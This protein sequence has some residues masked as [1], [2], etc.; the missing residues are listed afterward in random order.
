[1][2]KKPFSI[3]RHSLLMPRDEQSEYRYGPKNGG[4]A[5]F[6][7]SSSSSTSF[8]STNGGI[9]N[10]NK[11]QNNEG[12]PL[13]SL[14]RSL[15]QINPFKNRLFRLPA[16][17]RLSRSKKV[18]ARGE[19]FTNWNF[20]RPSEE[21]N[22]SANNSFSDKHGDSRD[23]SKIKWKTQVET[24][25]DKQDTDQYSQ[26]NLGENNDLDE[27]LSIMAK[28]TNKNE[29]GG[30]CRL[31]SIPDSFNQNSQLLEKNS[32]KHQKLKGDTVIGI[33]IKFNEFFN[34][35]QKLSKNGKTNKIRSRPCI[36]SFQDPKISKNN[37]E[38]MLNPPINNNNHCYNQKELNIKNKINHQNLNC[39]NMLPS[40][41][42]AP[43]GEIYA[44]CW[45]NN[46]YQQPNIFLP[47]SSQPPPS[48]PAAPQTQNLPL[49]QRP[50]NL[51]L[52]E[53]ISPQ[54]KQKLEK[55][56][57]L[58]L[59]P[60]SP[61]HS[62][63][64]L[65]NINGCNNVQ[66]QQICYA[67]NNNNNNYCQIQTQNASSS[68]AANS[69]RFPR[70]QLLQRRRSA[71]ANSPSEN[72]PPLERHQ[73]PQ[74]S[75]SNREKSADCEFE[76][77]ERFKQWNACY[78]GRDVVKL[79]ER[80]MKRKIEI[81]NNIKK[82]LE[83]NEENEENENK[84]EE[85]KIEKLLEKPPLIFNFE[86]ELIFASLNTENEDILIKE[87]NKTNFVGR[88]WIF[89]KLVEIL[90]EDQIKII[91]LVGA[92]G[93]GKSAIFRYLI[94][95]S[96]FGKKKVEKRKTSSESSQQQQNNTVDSGIVVSAISTN[97]SPLGSQ[98]SLNEDSSPQTSEQTSFYFIS[99][100]ICAFHLA[101]LHDSKRQLNQNY[102]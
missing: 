80:H 92:S 8:G 61:S 44:A 70:T 11:Q 16:T 31:P 18:L 85:N 21:D 69:I 35:S 2:D 78:Y 10:G 34:E 12:G 59:A 7:S 74:R 54:I 13:N 102:N 39:Y 100:N 81:E 3:R 43:D 19:D 64:T 50:Q 6:A 9:I 94:E 82:K 4:F 36:P 91:L 17:P 67:N 51:P 90:K 25:K 55:E 37:N 22:I 58:Q 84:N 28:I 88:K 63:I 57:N 38:E 1:M 96:H 72:P 97:P 45:R 56:E 79:M 48:V 15:R 98:T 26:I 32:E 29:I 20:E 46:H 60:K 86:E 87:N 33:D 23:Q 95:N 27:F 77:D 99:Q 49:S 89:N 66:Q 68:T 42:Y 83:L 62:A 41:R 65:L 5:F 93:T 30:S 24:D 73:R 71:A 53:F 76:K 101:H 75:R 52:K 47:N 14:R 40:T